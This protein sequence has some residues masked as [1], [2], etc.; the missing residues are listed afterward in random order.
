MTKYERWMAEIRI[1]WALQ[2]ERDA[3]IA[4]LRR[5]QKRED[6]RA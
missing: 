4:L 1:E 5:F 6:D 2:R 3:L